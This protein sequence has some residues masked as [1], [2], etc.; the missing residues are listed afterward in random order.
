MVTMYERDK[1]EKKKETDAE[2]CA[3]VKE[4]PYEPP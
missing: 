2:L 1:D 4:C 3:N